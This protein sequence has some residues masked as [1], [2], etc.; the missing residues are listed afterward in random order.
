MPQFRVGSG[1]RSPL[2]ADNLT[3]QHK[4]TSVTNQSTFN[5]ATQ[6]QQHSVLINKLRRRITSPP[7]T[8]TSPPETFFPFKIYQPTLAQISQFTNGICFLDPSS[9]AQ[10]SIAID[11]TRPTNL[12]VT[13]NP[14]TDAWRFFAVRSGIVEIRPNYTLLEMGNGFGSNLPYYS[15]LGDW[16]TDPNNWGWR[17]YVS[18]GTDFVSPP[19]DYQFDDNS[20]VMNSPPLVFTGTLNTPEANNFYPWWFA[21]WIAITPDTS[22][23]SLPTVQIAGC[24]A[25]QNDYGANFPALP[26]PNSNPNI[27]PIGWVNLLTSD[28]LGQEIIIDG[29]DWGTNYINQEIF[30]HQVNLY[31]KGNGNNSGFSSALNLRGSVYYPTTTYSPSDLASQV[32]YPGDVVVLNSF[33]GKNW[34]YLWNQSPM[35]INTPGYPTIYEGQIIFSATL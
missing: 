16:I 2:D 13:V 35:F 20:G 1:L 29:V 10:S 18:S 3:N 24:C 22:D 6:V 31:P 33:E 9:G 26:F 32:A 25:N 30:D 21:L 7:L 4:K 19:A 5:L 14:N 28:P 17:Y 15:G 12:P 27:I 11:A 34:M 8:P 23:A